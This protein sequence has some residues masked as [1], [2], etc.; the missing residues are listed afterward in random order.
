LLLNHE[1]RVLRLL[2][3]DGR[4][5]PTTVDPAHQP[6]PKVEP[7]FLPLDHADLAGRLDLI[8]FLT[9]AEN[10]ARIL[11]GFHTRGVVHT[12]I[13]PANILVQPTDLALRVINFGCVTNVAD[14]AASFDPVN[15]HREWPTYISPEQTGRMNRR[16]DYRTD[17]YSVGAVLYLLATGSPPFDGKDRLSLIHAHLA[18]AP[19]PPSESAAWMPN[20]LA[21]VIMTLLAKEPSD[22]YQSASGLLHDILALR[23][24]LAEGEAFENVRLRTHDLPLSPRPPHRLHGRRAELSLL[25]TQFAAVAEGGVRVLFVGGY[26]GIGKTSLIHEVYSAVTVGHGFFVTGKFEQFQRD[27][28]F[29]APAQS[30]HQLCNLLLAQPAPALADWRERILASIGPDAGALFE[31]LPELE[32]VLGKQPPVP[33]LGP[34]ETR[35]RLLSQLVGL[36]RG[37]ASAGCPIVLFL[38]DL[39]WADQPSLDFVSALLDERRLSGLLLIGAFRDHEV[40]A[41]HPLTRLLHKPTAWGDLPS[42]LTLTDLTPSHIAALLAEMLHMQA[43]ETRP[44][45]ELLH[46]KTGGNPFFTVEFVNALHRDGILRPDQEKARWHWDTDAISAHPASANVVEFLMAGLAS[47]NETTLDTLLAAACLGITSTL[48]L[49]AQATG[50]VPTALIDH[51]AP[52]LERGIML[53][54]DARAFQD[55]DPAAPLRFCHDRMLQAVYQRRD[56]AFRARVHLAIA[57][58]FAADSDNALRRFDAAEHYAIA[59]PLIVD[60]TEQSA[61]GVLFSQAAKQARQAGSFA[62]AEHFLRLA[63]GMLEANP[64]DAGHD[65]AFALY[66]ELH[67]TLY[68]QSR[69]ADAD[70]IYAR[71]VRDAPSPPKLVEAACIQVSSLS[72]RTRYDEAIRLAGD[73]LR[74]FGILMPTVDLVE[75]LSSELDLFYAHVNGGALERL[76]S[77][78]PLTDEALVHAS[79]LINRVEA[80][81]FLGNQTMLAFWL[82]LRNVR[83]C[84]EHGFCDAMLSSMCRLIYA[85]IAGRNDYATGYRTARI[86]LDMPV[87]PDRIAIVARAKYIFAVAANHWFQPVSDSTAHAHAAFPDL[88]RAGDLETSC[89]T[90]RVSQVSV[91]ETCAKLEELK[92]ESEQALAFARK[93]G[94]RHCEQVYL[95]FRQLVRALEGKTIGPGHFDDSEFTE[96]MHLAEVQGNVMALCYFHIYRALAACLFHDNAAFSWHAERSASYTPQFVGMYPNI[97]ANLLQSLAIIQKLRTAPPLESTS[98]QETLARNQAWL[99]A[100]AADAPMNFGH[101][102]DLVK[103]EELEVLGEPWQA[104]T[105]FEQAARKATAHQRPWHHALILERAGRF[106]MR[107]GLENAGRALLASAHDHFRLWG[108]EGKVLALRTEY[109][110]IGSS[111]IADDGRMHETALDY[112]AVL[113]AS[114]ALAS[115]TSLPLLVSRVVELVAQLTGAT[116]VLLLL[117][118]DVGEWRLEG[119][120]HSGEMTATE[121]PTME[122]AERR[123]LTSPT[124][125]RIIMNTLKPLVSD[126]AVIDSRFKDDPHFLGKPLCS[127]LALPVFVQGRVSGLL[128]LENS[129]YRGTFRASQI[130]TV[131]MLSVQLAISIENLRLYRSLERKVAER[132]QDLEI[133]NARLLQMSEIDG[134]TGIA[135]RRKFDAVWETECGRAERQ[136]LPLAVAL[137]DVDHFKAYND[138]YGHQAGDTCL[139]RIA[140]TFATYA[141]RGSHLVAR[142]GGE[143]FVV[144]LPG[145]DVGEATRFAESLLEAVAECRIPH[146]RNTAAPIVTVS[147]GVASRLPHSASAPG[148]ILKRADAALYQAKRSGRNRC[149][150]APEPGP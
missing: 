40:D 76:R 125:A 39:Q 45:A 9:L 44:L 132:T 138:T 97:L 91:F 107:H 46:A 96:A 147:I 32:A 20:R 29:L 5:R 48:G 115:E 127:L 22:R 74:Q 19:R 101:L 123:R 113:R 61:V 149:E 49:L 2:S 100:R 59:A 95:T 148:D 34:V 146:E 62:V 112:V 144:L 54:S 137:I 11:T 71:L 83:L 72:N 87:A 102:H 131:S 99:A 43:E 47:L 135:N 17:L 8:R 82:V 12:A 86:A 53:T 126:D 21:T 109:P 41:A 120:W 150:A 56:D 57:R 36:I 69:Y 124:V 106:H 35:M 26:S 1:D 133:A 84:V 88:L 27:R 52:V 90:F 111:R 75:H 78:P 15:R 73:L 145:M 66:A 50:S 3:I 104:Q 37:T 116:D 6:R 129:A 118:D 24:A 13:N 18:L 134:L 58:R 108:A 119:A 23:K 77:A 141:R 80:T 4:P 42:V 7:G 89:L 139:R 140:H 55:G 33:A 81:A 103:A 121:R 105:M 51:L 130:E 16:I 128:T 64:S 142:Y 79:R 14:E 92:S 136:H 110:F 68:C 60:P 70:V 31:I 65:A 143:E 93:T 28:P 122:E 25:M 10:L 98:L 63:I 114:H 85:T 117:L 30:L 94:N 67:V 38:D